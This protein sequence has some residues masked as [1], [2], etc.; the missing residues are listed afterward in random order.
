MNQ[1]REATSRSAVEARRAALQAE[2]ERIIRVLAEQ[3]AP[4]RII[5]FGSFAQGDIH[6]WS[7]LDLCVIK[8]TDKSFYARLKEVGVLTLP[9]VGCQIVV[10]TPDEWSRCTE[11]FCL[12]G[13][14]T[15]QQGERPRSP[16]ANEL[17]GRACS[18]HSGEEIATA[19]FTSQSARSPCAP[20][21]LLPH[22]SLHWH[23]CPKPRSVPDRRD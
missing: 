11:P 9:R 5:L 19:Q 18:D 2:L 4:E 22:R 17:S 20:Q 12:P 13:T 3:Y 1:T 10:Y 7:D 8:E 23:R 6:E 21:P 16:Q 15:A 14:M